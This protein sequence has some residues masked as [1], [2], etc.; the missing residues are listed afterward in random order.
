MDPQAPTWNSLELRLLNT[1]DVFVHK[2]AIMKKAEAE[3]QQLNSTLQDFLKNTPGLCP[4]EADT[5]KGQIAR[6]ENHKGFPFL[7]LDMP[8]LFSKETFFTFRTLFWWGHYLG[9]SLILQGEAMA[10]LAQAL[11][12]RTDTSETGAILFSVSATPWEWATTKDCFLPL[13]RLTGPEILSQWETRG[14]IK[15]LKS[16]PMNQDGFEGLN[17]KE[18]G[19]EAFQEFL[20]LV[21]K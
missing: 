18:T 17:W 2:P 5:T 15:L 20:R 16:F 1:V 13:N 3:L 19:L 6:G 10:P 11:A 7:S 9:F 4:P 21:G 8:Q 14:F 12:A